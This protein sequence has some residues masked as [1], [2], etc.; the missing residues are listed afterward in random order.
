MEGAGNAL[1]IVFLDAC[2][3]NPFARSLFVG[4]GKKAKEG[5]ASIDEA[6]SGTLIAYATK[7]NN[8]ALD[9]TGGGNSPYVKHL[10]REILKPGI[11]ILDMLTNVRMAVRKETKNKQAPAFYAELDRKFCFVE[12]CGGVQPVVVVQPKPTPPPTPAPHSTKIIANINNDTLY[13][14]RTPEKSEAN[15]KPHII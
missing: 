6:P 10:K 14:L 2:R 13:T 9:S 8:V 11:S 3:N 1:N 5:L 12:P 4:R 7:A 15:T